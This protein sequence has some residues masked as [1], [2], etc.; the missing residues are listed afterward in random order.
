MRNRFVALI[1]GTVL[2]CLIL[3]VAQA[4]GFFPTMDSLLGET[5]P[6][7]SSV[8]GR[9]ADTSDSGKEVYT[10]I[11]WNDYNTFGQYAAACGCE[12]AAYTPVENRE[13]TITLRKNGAD[14]QL[15]YQYDTG[16][17]TVVYPE[18][19]R[20]EKEPNTVAVSAMSKKQ[21]IFPSVDSLLGETMPA[22]S[23][24][25]GRKADIS[26]NRK[27][28]YTDFTEDDYN[29]FGR[30]AAAYGCLV[31]A[32]DYMQDKGRQV[33]ITLQKSGAS[34]Q[35]TYDPDAKTATVIYPEGTRMEAGPDTV[36]KS[37]MSVMSSFLP[38]LRRVFGAPLPELNRMFE[39]ERR[40]T[41]TEA[42]LRQREYAYVDEDRYLLFG[43]CLAAYGFQLTG[44]HV[45]D[46]MICAVA[47]WNGNPLEVTW[48][49]AEYQLTVTY[50]EYWYR[51]DSLW[52]GENGGVP[53]ILPD[54]E[55]MLG[56]AVPQL[57]LALN[58][59]PDRTEILPDSRYAE[60]YVKFGEADY[61]VFSDYL[62]QK[63]WE[64]VG[65]VK[66]GTV[67]KVTLGKGDKRF[68][69]EYDGIYHTGRTVYADRSQMEVK[70][71]VT[72]TPR[73]TATPRPSVTPTP[74]ATATP[75]P[76][77]LPKRYS[78]GECYNIAKRYFDSLLWKNPASV[79]LHGYTVTEG[80][81]GYLFMFDFSAMNSFGGYDRKTYYISVNF[82]TGQIEYALDL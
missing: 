81:T 28:V 30:Y 70:A 20:M 32:S 64:T 34:F 48:N 15:T 40:D 36:A 54:R 4:G 35:L 68:D 57:G 73:P 5:M 45:K 33:T 59:E 47:T 65:Y 25:I 72:P 76:T 75:R 3:P 10:N 39:Y 29:A 66:T 42:G 50:P 52:P 56:I 46:G 16:T 6:A 9:E 19:T 17:A 37:A 41:V 60:I 1:T 27:E 26:E 58:R 62:E 8:I 11:T 63:G 55:Q 12:M 61:S 69:F 77:K 71:M 80:D 13:V 74:R 67:L 51:D 49:P 43:S 79:T 53:S 78:E 82:F 21:S 38:E 14:F 44:S 18:G 23:S 2:I 31:A 24:A 7:L 22:V